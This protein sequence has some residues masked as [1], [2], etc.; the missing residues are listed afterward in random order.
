MIAILFVTNLSLA[1]SVFGVGTY[2]L[3]SY[4]LS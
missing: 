1:A 4:S 2:M 3:V